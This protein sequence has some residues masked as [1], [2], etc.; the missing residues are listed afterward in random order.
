MLANVNEELRNLDNDYFS[1]VTDLRAIAAT[2]AEKSY[3]EYTEMMIGKI[4]IIYLDAC[5]EIVKA[6]Q[7][8]RDEMKALIESFEESD[9]ANGIA[10]AK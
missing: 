4:S 7:R 3:D 10:R 5:A 8:G 6:S 1:R 9:R 2:M